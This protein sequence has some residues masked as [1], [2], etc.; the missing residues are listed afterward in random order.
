MF[1]R[2]TNF[3]IPFLYNCFWSLRYFMI[4]DYVITFNYIMNSGFKSQTSQSYKPTLSS[5]QTASARVPPKRSGSSAVNYNKLSANNGGM[6]TRSISVGT[7]NQAVSIHLIS[8]HHF[9]WTFFIAM[10]LLLLHFR[11][12]QI[13]MHQLQEVGLCAR[14]YRHKI[15][16]TVA[17]VSLDR[18]IYWNIEDVSN[19]FWQF[20]LLCWKLIF[21]FMKWFRKGKSHGI[22]DCEKWT[23]TIGCMLNVV[24]Y[25][26]ILMHRE[27]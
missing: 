18:N 26:I 10:N 2:C 25:W 17:T 15:K 16:L 11:A 12:T 27:F 22:C 1:W 20:F 8:K 23:I 5:R 19:I 13:Q 4:Y 24:I 6:G 9:M 21:F 3:A 14:P 7:L